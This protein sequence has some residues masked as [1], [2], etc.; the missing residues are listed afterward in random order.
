MKWLNFIIVFCSS[1]FTGCA[2]GPLGVSWGVPGTE[3]SVQLNNSNEAAAMAIIQQNCT[4]CHGSSSGPQGIYGLTDVN[5]LV[6]SG[7]VV[8]GQPNQS[9]LYTAVLSNM[10]P[11]GLLSAADIQVLNA[12]ISGSP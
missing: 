11:T 9:T 3:T 1:I 6:N 10:P 4:V 8:A 5:H 12:W 2:Q 7:L